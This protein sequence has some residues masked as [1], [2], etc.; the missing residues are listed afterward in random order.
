MPAEPRIL[1]VDDDADVLELSA[2][3]LARA[4]FAITT[5]SDGSAALDR[6][7]NEAP[8]AGLVTDDA[9]PGLSGRTLIA[10]ARAAQPG[11][12]CLLISGRIDEAP[13]D[14]AYRILRKPFRA[15]ALA[16]AV[17]VMMAAPDPA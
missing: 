13:V 14:G 15:A 8:F 17:S 12:R 4:G 6:L 5:A 16:V 10:R 11:L 7:T 2:S 9:M 3:V 1:L